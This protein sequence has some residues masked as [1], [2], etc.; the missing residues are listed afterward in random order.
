MALNP[1][2]AFDVLAREIKALDG[3]RREH[4]AD[5]EDL[6]PHLLMSDISRWAEHTDSIDSADVDV[7]L[8][9]L[10]R[11]YAEG[12]VNVQNMINVSFIEML[13]EGS[14]LFRRFGP[15]LDG[16]EMTIQLNPRSRRTRR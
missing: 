8:A 2:E 14:P 16:S 12:D 6:L 1:A 5:F 13:D 10:D 15:N 3:L 11:L 9:L 7:L 4:L